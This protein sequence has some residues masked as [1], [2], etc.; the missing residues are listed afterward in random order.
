MVSRRRAWSVVIAL[1]ALLGTTVSAA[2]PAAAVPANTTVA[3]VPS[4]P[5][6][7]TTRAG[8]DGV[9]L[10]VVA[11]GGDGVRTRT[12]VLRRASLRGR[13]R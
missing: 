7:V 1:S 8:V 5:T 3:G 10:V 13:P 12:D 11:G 4:A 2:P 9:S 6:H